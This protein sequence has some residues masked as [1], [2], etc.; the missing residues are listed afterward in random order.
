[1]SDDF[2]FES[3]S[4]KTLLSDQNKMLNIPDYQRGYVW[5]TKDQGERLWRDIMEV[6]NGEVKKVFL[7]PILVEQITTSFGADNEA[8]VVDGQQRLLTL[9]TLLM[10]L[11]REAEVQKNTHLASILKAYIVFKNREEKWLSLIH[12]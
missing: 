10:A 1:M 6:I 12:I 4:L 11:L 2:T 8:M 3:F 9:Y 7:G 5:R